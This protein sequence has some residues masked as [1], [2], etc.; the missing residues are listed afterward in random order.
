MSFLLTARKALP[1][2]KNKMFGPKAGF[3]LYLDIL[4][5][6]GMVIRCA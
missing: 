6:F 3:L 4:A 2:L 5:V 1:P